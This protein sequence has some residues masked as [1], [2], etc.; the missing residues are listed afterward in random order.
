MTDKIKYYLAV[1]DV[2]V[3]RPRCQ[4]RTHRTDPSIL[5]AGRRSG[6]I[7]PPMGPNVILAIIFGMLVLAL[8]RCRAFGAVLGVSAFTTF[9]DPIVLGGLSFYSI[10]IT[11][12]FAM[13]R[14]IARGELQAV[15]FRAFDALVLAWLAVTTLLY[16]ALDGSYVNVTER[17]GYLFD[18][19]GL[20]IIVRALIRNV[21]D[22]VET[23]GM[24]ALL[25]IPLA[26]FMAV[27][28]VTGRNPFAMLGGVA[29]W[30]IVR[31]GTVRCQ[32]PFK[33]P[34]LAGSFGA[35]AFPLMV[36]LL[37]FRPDRRV[38]GAIGAVS[39]AIIV[40]VSGSS[41]PLSALVVSVLGL[42]MWWIRAQ[43]RMV[44]WGLLATVVALAIFMKRPVWFALDKLSELTGGDGWYR[45]QLINSAVDHI[46]EWWLIGTG[47]TA[48]WM[49]TGIPVSPYS[50][51]IVNEF[52]NQGIRGGLVCLVLFVIVLSRTFA[53]M[54]TAVKAALT[55][56]GQRYFFWAMGCSL[57]AHVA[58]FFSVTYFDQIIA[59]YY[60]VI[61]ST[62]MAAGVS[63]SRLQKARVQAPTKFSL[64]P[65][66]QYRRG[67][68]PIGGTPHGTTSQD[69][70]HVC[71]PHLGSA[72]G[73]HADTRRKIPRY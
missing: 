72:T 44:Q 64:Y 40:Y 54:G 58:S 18:V 16:V 68:A 28:R 59:V 62:V 63:D 42:G 65:A 37:V 39:A 25:L 1:G 33:H 6:T 35:A 4:C 46:G 3:C 9:G 52:I 14:I 73:A 20:Y 8:P 7:C 56:L 36:G 45:S 2:G 70:T 50:A 12:M 26:V 60:L 10:R 67:P 66:R 23:V 22:L 48:H 29:D 15:R 13:A 71:V 69:A 49:G 55:A 32:G 31:N 47:Y 51:D 34:I 57:A 41:G 17:L 19:G 5:L 38:F 53:A 24:L 21:D 27:E 30:S 61:G 11:I 43:I